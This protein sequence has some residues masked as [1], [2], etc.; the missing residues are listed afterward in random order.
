MLITEYL[1][2]S[3]SPAHLF[4][5]GKGL[6]LRWVYHYVMNQHVSYINIFAW[7]EILLLHLRSLWAD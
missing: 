6:E 7:I 2:A 3:A 4:V 1:A 5:S